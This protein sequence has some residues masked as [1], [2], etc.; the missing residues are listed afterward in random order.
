[1]RELEFERDKAEIG[2]ARLE[3]KRWREIGKDARDIGKMKERIRH[4]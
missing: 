4:T 1:V 2:L 3:K